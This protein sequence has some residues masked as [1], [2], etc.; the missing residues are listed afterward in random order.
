[1]AKDVVAHLMMRFFFKDAAKH[2]TKTTKLKEDF[3]KDMN[4]SLLAGTVEKA[5]HGYF[6]RLPQKEQVSITY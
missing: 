1:M 6:G 4:Y 3:L 2:K 5:D